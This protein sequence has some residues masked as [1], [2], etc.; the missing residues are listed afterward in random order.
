MGDRHLLFGRGRC[1]DVI[2]ICV[3]GNVEK[4]GCF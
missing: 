1:R 3:F 2:F 4:V